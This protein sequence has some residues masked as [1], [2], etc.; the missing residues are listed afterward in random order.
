LYE[1]VL[2]CA[3]TDGEALSPLDSPPAGRCVE[4]L[5][6][7]RSGCVRVSLGVRGARVALPRDKDEN[8][9]FC[10]LSSDM[11]PMYWKMFR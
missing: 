2:A 8:K 9:P 3:A 6:A 4:E 10:C 5:E 1:S 11:S 7:P